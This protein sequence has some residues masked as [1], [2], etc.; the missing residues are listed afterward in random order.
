[1]MDNCPHH[2]TPLVR[3]LLQDLRIPTLFPASASFL[4]APVELAFGALKAQDFSEA[5]AKERAAAALD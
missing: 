2:K 5:L 1:M 3:R 4:A